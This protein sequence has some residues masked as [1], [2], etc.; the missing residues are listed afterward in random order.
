MDPKEYNKDAQPVNVATNQLKPRSLS[1]YVILIYRC[2]GFA[3]LRF[4]ILPVLGHRISCHDT[5]S[6]VAPVRCYE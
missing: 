3:H 4:S 6:I 5:G 2:S 1:D